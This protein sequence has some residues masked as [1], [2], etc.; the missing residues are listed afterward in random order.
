[1]SDPNETESDMSE[2][3]TDT[4]PLEREF[5]EIVYWREWNDLEFEVYDMGINGSDHARRM[6]KLDRLN[7]LSVRIGEDA[8]GRAREA[9]V[10]RF[11][12]K[13]AELIRDKVADDVVAAW[14]ARTGG[15]RVRFAVVRGLQSV[16]LPEREYAAILR[17]DGGE[18]WL[19]AAVE[20]SRQETL[21]GI[22]WYDNEIGWMTESRQ[23]LVESLE[24]C[25]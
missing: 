8:R 21:E 13:V 16:M 22:A 24:R 10:R 9:G 5:A 23:Q 17:E 20:K 18:G 11:R 7:E 3:L 14:L 15:P 1:M 2:N 6:E 25:K 4:A 19:D 12:E